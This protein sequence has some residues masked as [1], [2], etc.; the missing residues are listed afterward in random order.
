MNSDIF[1][2]SNLSLKSVNAFSYFYFRIFKL[3]IKWE[4]KRRLLPRLKEHIKSL[5]KKFRGKSKTI[6]QAFI[7]FILKKRKKR[8][9][10]KKMHKFSFRRKH[11]SK[12]WRSYKRKF[13]K[14]NINVN[15]RGH[16]ILKN[17]GKTWNNKKKAA[18]KFNKPI[19]FVKDVIIKHKLP[20][21]NFHN[22]IF[23]NTFIRKFKNFSMIKW[24]LNY[25]FL[26]KNKFM[27][28]GR[29][30][31]TPIKKRSKLS[32]RSWLLK[33]KFINPI[34][35]RKYINKFKNKGKRKIKRTLVIKGKSKRKSKKRTEER[36][37]SF[38]PNELAVLSFAPTY[39]N[40]YTFFLKQEGK[41][42][43]FSWVI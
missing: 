42:G 20:K 41:S 36:R 23:K 12:Y 29:Q 6:K 34:L 5:R 4:P 7:K 14:I 28:I 10:F 32:I 16:K 40:S 33:T 15:K 27:Q 24:K 37:E 13:K 18:Y 26:T 22:I 31:S 38:I 30:V 35:K 11:Y 19:K 9:W 39:K 1:F 17:S 43:P 2:I 25:N 8:N 3:A 21:R